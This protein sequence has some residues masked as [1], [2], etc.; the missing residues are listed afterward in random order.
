MPRVLIIEDEPGIRMTLEDRLVAEGY[1]CSSCGDGISG[2]ATAMEGAWDLILLD[3]MLP[4][5]DGL[6]ICRNLR[7][8]ERD[9]PILMLTARNTDL[10][11]IAGLGIGADDY[12][13]KPFDMG[14]LLARMEALTRRF[15]R[16]AKYGPEPLSCPVSFGRFILDPASGKLSSNGV[17][18]T[19]FAQEYRLLEYLVAH[20]DRLLSRD[21]ILDQVWGYQSDTTTR[22]VDV[23]VAKLRRILGE[24]DLPRHILTIRGR[25]YKFTA[26]E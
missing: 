8:A 19:L 2:E 9:T 22:T 4:G 26:G 5:R 12:L 20:P 24:S 17:E 15:H 14:V 21:E 10:D 11:V 23:H 6:T 13:A 1:A 16:P 7:K 18:V 3:L 25:G